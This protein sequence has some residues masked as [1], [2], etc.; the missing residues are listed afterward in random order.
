MKLRSGT[1]E[2]KRGKERIHIIEFH[3]CYP[4]NGFELD[5]KKASSSFRVFFCF[6]LIA[7]WATL[8]FPP[9]GGRFIPLFEMDG[10]PFCL[11]FF[12]FL[13]RTGGGTQGHFPLFPSLCCF[14]ARMLILRNG[15]CGWVGGISFASFSIIS[16]PSIK[17]AFRT[18]QPIPHMGCRYKRHV[19]GPVPF[20]LRSL[21]MPTIN[22]S[23]R[24]ILFSWYLLFAKQTDA[25]FHPQKKPVENLTWA[26]EKSW[27]MQM[28]YLSGELRS[29]SEN[30]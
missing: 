25:F 6:E 8:L 20:L 16:C 23:L 13:Y 9:T 29:W 18:N 7:Q 5:P 28:E 22:S 27:F 17:T 4:K 2:K 19:L 11:V 21:R 24:S 26:M 1:I 10:G 15:K 14:I 3:V 12:F 30:N